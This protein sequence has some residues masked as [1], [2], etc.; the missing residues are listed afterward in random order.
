[1]GRVTSCEK[2]MY[3]YSINTVSRI[4]EFTYSL[5]VSAHT[6]DPTRVRS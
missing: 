2:K 1:M 5:A 6:Q 3:H 4:H